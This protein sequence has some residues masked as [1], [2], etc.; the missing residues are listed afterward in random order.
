[1]SSAV[2]ALWLDVTRRD[3]RFD[4]QAINCLVLA[5]GVEAER[6]VRL[7]LAFHFVSSA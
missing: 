1:M 4:Q 2:T 5:G 6:A 3:E 7:I